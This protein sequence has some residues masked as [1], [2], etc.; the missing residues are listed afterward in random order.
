MTPAG[1]D[2]RKHEEADFIAAM[3][4][5]DD[6]LRQR[7]QRGDAGDAQGADADPGAG[8]ELEIFSDA[9]V[10]EQSEFGRAGS[11]KVTASPI[12]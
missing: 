12:R 6:I 5:D 8:I 9:A 3:A 4:G 10:E 11:A 2:I 1:R 7:R